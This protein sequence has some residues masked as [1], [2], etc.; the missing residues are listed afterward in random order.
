[1]KKLSIGDREI[2]GGFPT[3]II[4]EA[5]VNHNG[6]LDTALEL[7]RKAKEIGVDCIKF[8]TFKAEAVVTK[9]APKADY[10]L[11]V[12]NQEESQYEMLKSLELDFESYKVILSECDSVGIDFLSTPYNKDDVDFLI[13]LGVQGF[14][15]ASGQ[16]IELDFLKYVAEKK[17]P[18]IISSGMGTLSEISKAIETI[19][20]TGNDEIVLLQCVTNYP[21]DIE[22]ANVLAMPAMSR[23]LDIIVGYSDHVP[24]NY[25]TYAAVALGA[26]IVEKHFTL[27]TKMD[28][29]D[30]SSSL[31]VAGFQELVNGIRAVES[32]LGDSNKKPM[33]AEIR[34]SKG[35]RRSIVFKENLEKG[36]VLTRDN[37]T[38]KRP[39]TGLKPE[40]MDT[41]LGK[42]L[43]AA[44]NQD[45]MLDYK[46]IAW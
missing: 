19:R 11:K 16:L 46:H 24:S 10:Q 41:F 28:G 2:G 25:A 22:D 27:D 23:A 5:G 29:P 30:H 20:E 13:K 33:E 42:K 40:M 1:M 43:S 36:T 37:L 6:D 15:I 17:L 26:T 38:F 3:Y 8:Q 34:N 39:A 4:A 9:S 44:V 7:V 45:E 14:K 32:S 21:A 35:M 12:T 31:D 18:I